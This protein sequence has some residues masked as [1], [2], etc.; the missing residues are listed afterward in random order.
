MSLKPIRLV[1]DIDINEGKFDEFEAIVKRMAEVSAQEPGTLGY[2]FLLNEDRTRC[3]LVEG[4]VDEAAIAAHFDGPAV[5]EWVPKLVQVAIPS[6]MEIYGDPG[7]Q[8]A[9]KAATLGAKIFAPWH[10]FDR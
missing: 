6:R 7:P 4:Y 1:V 10:G 3:R 9:A 8:V 5:K 2:H